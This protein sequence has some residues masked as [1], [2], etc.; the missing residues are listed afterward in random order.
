MPADQ[1]LIDSVANA[2]T[3]V[4]AESTSFWMSQAMGNHIQSQ[5]R[6]Q[7]LAETALAKSIELLQNISME[8]ASATNKV[9]TGN[10]VAAQMQSLLAALNSGQQGVKSAGNTPPVTP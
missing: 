4:M 9:G 8:E 3:K 7:I 6:L 10:D 2:N 1:G 5:N